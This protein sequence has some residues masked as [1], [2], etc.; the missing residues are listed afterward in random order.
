MEGRESR[1]MGEGLVIGGREGVMTGG[2]TRHDRMERVELHL[3]VVGQQVGL[4][5]VL[6]PDGGPGRAVG[7]DVLAEARG[8]G[9]ARHARLAPCVEAR[10]RHITSHHIRPTLP[11]GALGEIEPDWFREEPIREEPIISPV[12]HMHMSHGWNELKLHRINNK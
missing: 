10:H 6:R 12:N 3:V 9:A 5:L 1:Q 2:T 11:K 8:R 7:P 4:Q